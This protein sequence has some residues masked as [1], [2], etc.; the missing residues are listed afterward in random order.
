M[1][2]EH[3]A[4]VAARR[5]FRT[6]EAGHYTSL[7]ASTLEKL[8]ITGGGPRFA[9]LGR[10]IVYDVR[11]LDEWIDARKIESTSEADAR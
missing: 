1:A 6:P 4:V 2:H 10:V 11:D 9:R 5:L 7:A 8:R 3:P